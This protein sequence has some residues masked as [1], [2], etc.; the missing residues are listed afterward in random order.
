MSRSHIR[1]PV[2]YSVAY[3]IPA[4]ARLSKDSATACMFTSI[5]HLTAENIGTGY[6][7]IL[8]HI[9][10]QNVIFLTI[11]FSFKNDPTK[12][13]FLL[14]QKYKFINQTKFCY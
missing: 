1:S 8:F 2:T 9:L 3:Y 6:T 12:Q 4:H 5:H 13:P 14:A 7:Q 10:L 11:T